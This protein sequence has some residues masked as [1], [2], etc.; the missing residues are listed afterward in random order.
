MGC[1]LANS[2]RHLMGRVRTLALIIIMVFGFGSTTVFARGGGH[3][4]GG[5]GAW[6]IGR[7][8]WSS[9]WP[10]RTSW[11]SHQR[12]AW[13]DYRRYNGEGQFH[14]PPLPLSG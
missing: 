11:G 13:T 14:E 3:S 9:R 5:H 10:Q 7:A 6:P 2:T 8:W 4:G 12:Q 1:F